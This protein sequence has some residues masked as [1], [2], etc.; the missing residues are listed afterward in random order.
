V[1]F[2]PDIST[3][4]PNYAH[5]DYP[6]GHATV[7]AATEEVLTALFPRAAA[8]FHSRAAED[9][10]SRVRAGIHF[11]SACAAGLALGQSVG[12]RVVERLRGDGAA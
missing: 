5:P 4:L 1:H 3:L 12:G 10:A 2:D 9:A 7:D 6:G 8:A 11:P